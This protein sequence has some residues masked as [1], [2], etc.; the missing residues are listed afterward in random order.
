MLL[1]QIVDTTGVYGISFWVAAVNVLVAFA[2]VHRHR[3]R[4]VVPA[5]LIVAAMTAGILG[6]GRFRLAEQTTRPGAGVLVVQPNYPQSNTGG[7]GAD[8]AE[9]LAFHINSTAE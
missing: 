8:P 7:K 1:C 9:M 5:A 2:I 4:R 6:Y 3:L